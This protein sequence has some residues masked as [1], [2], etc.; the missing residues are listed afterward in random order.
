MA[1]MRAARKESQRFRYIQFQTHR[2]VS[3]SEQV[4]HLRTLLAQGAAKRLH[5]EQLPGYAPD[6]NSQEGIWNLLKRRQL[7]NVCC[8]DLDE[9]TQ[10]FLWAKGR[11]R[12]R[13]GAILACFA[14]AACPL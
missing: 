4:E 8:R 13:R 6:L 5:M 9:L 7:K 12:H 11:L 1:H 3:S 14:H 10:K 2:R